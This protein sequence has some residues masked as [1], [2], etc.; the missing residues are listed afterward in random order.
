MC[1]CGTLFLEV[2]H[3]KSRTRGNYVRLI[4]CGNDSRCN[5]VIIFMVDVQKERI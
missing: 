5:Y 1:S 2:L 3:R 4:I